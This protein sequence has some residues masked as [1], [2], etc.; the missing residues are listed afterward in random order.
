[1][2][3]ELSTEQRAIAEAADQLLAQHAGPQRAVEL[4]AR[5]AYDHELDAALAAAGFSEAALGPETGFL[6][7]ALLVEAVAR[8][9][10]V[11][12]F[13]AAAL[14][15]PGVAGR[16]LPGPVALVRGGD[17][18]PVRFGAHARTLLV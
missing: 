8:A 7:A 17:T 1:M 11:V 9:G 10:G 13:A 2:D 5:D 14:V 15:A 12:A 6:E 16:A 18:A 4:S 3:F